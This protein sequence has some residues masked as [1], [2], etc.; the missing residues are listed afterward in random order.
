MASSTPRSGRGS[1]FGGIRPVRSLRTTASQTAASAATSVAVDARR[2][3]GR[4][5]RRSRC[6]SRRS[7]DRRLAIAAA[8]N[9]P[10][11]ATTPPTATA[12]TATAAMSPRCIQLPSTR[13]GMSSARWLA[14]NSMTRKS[15]S[16]CLQNGSSLH[17]RLDLVAALADRENDA[18]VARNLAPRDEERPGGV[19]LLQERHM[20][21]HLR[22]DLR[23]VRPYR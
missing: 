18:A 19:V 10:R 3:R 6:G 11:S 15:A 20:R 8:T 4:P 1:P 17:D 9:A 14:R 2:T 23:R 7:S 13:F 5:R 16:P 12:A 22:V 21:A